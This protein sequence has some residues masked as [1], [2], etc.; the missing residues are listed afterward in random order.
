MPS[1]A[2]DVLGEDG[3]IHDDYRIEYLRAHIQAAK[4]AVSEDGVDLRAYCPW[5]ALDVVSASTGELAKRYGFIFVDYH[6][7]GT[8]DG[9]RYRKDSFHWYK[10]VIESNGEQL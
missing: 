6:D 1:G 2:K 5:T 8:G 4:E 3:T 7:D 10:K 9:S